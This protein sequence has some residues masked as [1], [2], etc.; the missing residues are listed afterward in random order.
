MR[1]SSE[2]TSMR[3]A[4]GFFS[5]INSSAL[6][7]GVGTGLRIGGGPGFIPH[8]RA[9]EDFSDGAARSPRCGRRFPDYS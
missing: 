2:S 3:A 5:A 1:L 8:W 9:F 4:S 7:T 6:A